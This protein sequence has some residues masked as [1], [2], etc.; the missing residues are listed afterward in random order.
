MDLNSGLGIL[1]KRQI[2]CICRDSNSGSSSPTM[3][4]WLRSKTYFISIG[5]LRSQPTFPKSL[6]FLVIHMTSLQEALYILVVPHHGYMPSPSISLT[7]FPNTILTV[8]TKC[9]VW[10]GSPLRHKFLRPLQI[11][12]VNIFSSTL[13]LQTRVKQTTIHTHKKNLLYCNT[14]PDIQPFIKLATGNK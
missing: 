7:I 12:W 6:I 14:N 13:C 3:L 9:L 8:F 1:E 11:S 2:S 4:S 10:F 5:V